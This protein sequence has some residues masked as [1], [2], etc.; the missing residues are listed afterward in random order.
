MEMIWFFWLQVFISIVI[1]IHTYHIAQYSGISTAQQNSFY[2]S[3]SRW[4]LQWQALSANQINP[5][6]SFN[7]FYF[8]NPLR[9]MVFWRMNRWGKT[10]SHF[11]VRPVSL[12]VFHLIFLGDMKNSTFATKQGEIRGLFAMTNAKVFP[13]AFLR[14]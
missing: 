9:F 10:L 13:S 14:M 6:W 11:S 4:T 1:V 8:W 2:W 12:F 3:R 5:S 7:Y